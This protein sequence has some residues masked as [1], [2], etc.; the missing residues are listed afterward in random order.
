MLARL[1]GL[2]AAVI[3]LALTSGAGAQTPRAEQ[4]W[5]ADGAP[6]N[7]I[8]TSS[9]RSTEVVDDRTINFVVSN[10]R[11][12]VNTLPRTCAGL[13]ANRAFSS[14]SRTTQLCAANTITVVQ[15]GNRVPGS[16]CGLG[17]FQPMRMVTGASAAEP[18]KPAN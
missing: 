6:V 14:D 4:R 12:F 5:V 1:A 15:R 13:G 3:G 16:R 18:A 9:V 8:R 10:T 2:G 7:C 17:Q 11:L